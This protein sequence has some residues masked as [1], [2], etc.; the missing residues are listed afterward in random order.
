M[1]HGLSGAAAVI[2][3]HAIAVGI[4]T[5]F[6]CDFFRGQEKMPDE[7]LVGRGRA[8]DLGDVLPGNDEDVDGRLGTDVLEG[9]HELVL[10]HDIGRDLSLDDLTEDAVRIA[11]HSFF[12]SP[13]PE[14]PLKKQLRAP[15]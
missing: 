10:V 8:V 4:E 9:G 5:F 15:V 7:V 12:S 14:K 6:L 2:D 11:D 3:D 13:G 1:E